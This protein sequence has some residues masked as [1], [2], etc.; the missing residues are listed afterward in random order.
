MNPPL[1]VLQLS[2]GSV[3]PVAVLVLRKLNLPPQFSCQVRNRPVKGHKC[4]QM[5]QTTG[6]IGDA[7]Q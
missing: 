6:R 7:N 1:E 5:G 2:L 4:D 3:Q